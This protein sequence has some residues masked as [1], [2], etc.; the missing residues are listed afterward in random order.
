MNSSKYKYLITIIEKDSNGLDSLMHCVKQNNFKLLQLYIKNCIK[1]I[2]TNAVD[3]EGKSLVHY[4]VSPVEEGSFENEVLLNHLLEKGFV[5][6]LCK[7][8]SLRPLCL[9]GCTLQGNRHAVV[10]FLIAENARFIF[11]PG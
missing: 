7:A 11:S 9:F 10:Q 3:N 1:N 5:A 4:A 8:L 2:S 6:L